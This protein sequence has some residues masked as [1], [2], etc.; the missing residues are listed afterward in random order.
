MKNSGKC[1]KCSTEYDLQKGR[2]LKLKAI[3]YKGGK[4][5]RCNFIGHYSSLVFHHTNPNEKEFDWY[6]G[7]KQKWEIL[8]LEL[9]KCDLLCANCHNLIHSKLNNDGTPNIEYVEIDK[10]RK[11]D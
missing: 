8:K 5:K 7:R 3:E 11:N 1:R 2:E 6:K 9:D 4:C 10:N